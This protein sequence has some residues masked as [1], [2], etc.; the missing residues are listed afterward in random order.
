MGSIDDSGHDAAYPDNHSECSIFEVQPTETH[1]PLIAS[2][3]EVLLLSWLLVLL[4][5]QED[6]RASFEWSSRNLKDGVEHQTS[7]IRLSTDDVLTESHLQ[8]SFSQAAEAV[9]RHIKANAPALHA[10][11]PNEVS[12]FVSTGSLSHEPDNNDHEVRTQS[13]ITL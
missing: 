7:N 6:G 1:S 12:I 11:G 4:R 9:S 3:N 5:T 13:G 10:A 2:S 8:S